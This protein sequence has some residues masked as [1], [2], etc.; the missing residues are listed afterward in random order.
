MS[1]RL[2]I[3]LTSFCSVAHSASR[4]ASFSFKRRDFGVDRGD[5][6]LLLRAKVAVADQR[7]LLLLAR[8]DRGGRVLDHRRHRAL[9]DG[10]A[11]RGGVEQAHGL[12][13]QLPRRNVAM[14]EVHG[15]H[16][17]GVGNPHLVMLLHRPE[18]A[19]QHVA[20]ASHVRLVDLDRLEAPRQRRVLFDVLAI[21]RPGRRRDGA[22][23]AARQAP[24]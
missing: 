9:A 24:A 7:R 21:F 8:R 11:R 17:G 23:R 4:P 16:D 6:L 19:A 1:R 10:D 2:R 22:Q 14:R 13:G 18:N 20:A 3:S 5:A 12:V 15:R